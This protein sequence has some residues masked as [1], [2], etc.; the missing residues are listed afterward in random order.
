ME[1][2]R[3]RTDRP[4]P[5]QGA[6][7]LAA[8]ARRAPLVDPDDVDH[9][10]L[11]GEDLQSTLA[12]IRYVAIS[13]EDAAALY[14]AATRRR[15]A[16]WLAP[17]VTLRVAAALAEVFEAEPGLRPERANAVHAA[18]T[19]MDHGSKSVLTGGDRDPDP[20]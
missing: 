7:E 19:G 10:R 5:G 16:G 4:I 1:C 15:A 14:K 9:A 13:W 17:D 3:A 20:P 12:V 11:L 18:E 2:R 8:A 6:A